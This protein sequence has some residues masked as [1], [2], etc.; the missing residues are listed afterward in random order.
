MRTA[1]KSTLG[2]VSLGLFAA[3]YQIGLTAETGFTFAEPSATEST[4][5]DGAASSQIMAEPTPTASTASVTKTGDV[6]DV[7]KGYGFVQVEVVKK[8]DVITTIK[9]LRAESS[10][11]RDKAFPSLV[12]AAIKANGSNFGNISN[13]TY[14][15]NA[16]KKAVESALA[17]F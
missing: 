15:T 5:P 16:F 6:I 4:N 10:D 7:G 9:L 12:A 13:A 14:T 17:K 2:L 1:T 3:S 8:G 11:G